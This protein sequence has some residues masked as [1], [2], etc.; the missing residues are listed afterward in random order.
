MITPN[1]SA[2]QTYGLLG[3]V[4]L[5]DTSTGSDGT[6]TT[7]RI[8]F[9]KQ[10]GTYLVPTG[11]T[12]SYVVWSYAQSSIAIAGLL[13]KDYAL[14]ITVQWY[15]GATLVNTKTILNLFS[16]VA[17]S[18]LYD[19]TRYA[20]SNQRLLNSNNFFDNKSKLQVLED[21]AAQAVTLPSGGDISA[22]QLCL[23]MAKEIVDN[24]SL[25]H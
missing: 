12:T 2:T 13:D 8:Y 10:D 24:P 18:F 16:G 21:D 20:A 5:T 22:A 14:D 23:N 17:K 9:A 19:L 25:F 7:R 6:L 15:A 11:T 4:T 1:F 3:T